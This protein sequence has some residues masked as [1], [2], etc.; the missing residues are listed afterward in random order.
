[1]LEWKTI[2]SFPNYEMSVFG[3]IREKGTDTWVDQYM[4]RAN[5]NEEKHAR[6]RLRRDGLPIA[7]SVQELVYET[8]PHLIPKA[9]EPEAPVVIRKPPRVRKLRPRRSSG[10]AKPFV[11][12]LGPEW[13]SIPGFQRYKINKKGQLINRRTKS[14]VALRKSNKGSP[15]YSLLDDSGETKARHPETLLN[16]AYPETIVGRKIRKS[17]VMHP[18]G[19]YRPIPGRTM[20]EIHMSGAVRRISRH[21]VTTLEDDQGYPYVKLKTDGVK[22]FKNY[23][24]NDLL[25]EVYGIELKEAA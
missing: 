25:R 9:E 19:E 14:L 1:M 11:D 23:Y 18:P 3:D 8:Y 10:R 15:N 21:R 4:G 24:I 5:F 16:L 7:N 6:V 13:A 12:D 17:A 22:G 2:P 20:Y